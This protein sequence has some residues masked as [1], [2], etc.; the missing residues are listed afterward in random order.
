MPEGGRS[1]A[2][3]ARERRVVIIL[4]TGPRH[5]KMSGAVAIQEG[6]MKLKDLTGNKYGYWTVIERS[7]TDSHRNVFWLCRCKCGTERPVRAWDLT[8]GKS[9]SCGCRTHEPTHGKAL[10]HGENC[11]CGGL[12]RAWCNMRNRKLKSS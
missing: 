10:K 5:G 12:Y 2:P 9:K 3:C 4:Q 8:S 7:K 11:A 6:I 1:F